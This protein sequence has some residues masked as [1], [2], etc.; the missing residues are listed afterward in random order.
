MDGQRPESLCHW[1]EFDRVDVER[2]AVLRSNGP[3]GDVLRRQRVCPRRA[4]RL[5]PHRHETALLEF[6]PP[7]RPAQRR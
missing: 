1:H 6:R 5:L 7:T 3:S 4:S 2:G